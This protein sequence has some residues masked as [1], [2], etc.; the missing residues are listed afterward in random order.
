[1]SPVVP[2]PHSRPLR[3]QRPAPAQAA[4]LPHPSWRIDGPPRDGQAR[5]ATAEDF[6]QRL[7]L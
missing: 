1:M 7:G 3:R 2:Q 6:F 4:R 5:P